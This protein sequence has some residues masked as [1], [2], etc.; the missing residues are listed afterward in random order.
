MFR[1]MGIIVLLVA[2]AG[3]GAEPEQDHSYEQVHFPD[4]QSMEKPVIESKETVSTLVKPEPLE[5]TVIMKEH[6]LDGVIETTT[7]KETIWSMMDFWAEYKEWTVESQEIDRVVFQREVQDISPLTKKQ[8]YFGLTEDGDLAVFQGQ[9]GEG[10][11]IQSFKP[12]PIKPLESKRKSELE[13]GIKIQ[14]YQHFEQVLT[15][16]SHEDPV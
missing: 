11:I 12:V 2:V 10:K 16:F 14:S 8:G 1:W 15:Q 4:K 13:N 3:C 9:P 5:L 7:T 6:Y